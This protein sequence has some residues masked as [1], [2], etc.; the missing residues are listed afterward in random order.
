MTLLSS[1]NEDN[2]SKTCLDSPWHG[3]GIARLFVSPKPLTACLDVSSLRSTV[4]QNIGPMGGS[5]PHEEARGNFEAIVS[6]RVR[7]HRSSFP[8]RQPGYGGRVL[9]APV[10]RPRFN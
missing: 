1:P 9:H 6:G 3:A 10:P 2:G 4:E 8:T 7:E 5:V